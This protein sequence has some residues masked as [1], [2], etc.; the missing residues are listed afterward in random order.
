[1]LDKYNILIF[2]YFVVIV[3]RTFNIET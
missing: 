3:V 2:V 1:M